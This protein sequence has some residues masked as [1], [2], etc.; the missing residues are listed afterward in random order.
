M[1]QKNAMIS[2]C[3][4]DALRRR[5]LL[6]QVRE[7]SAIEAVQT[8]TRQYMRAAPIIDFAIDHYLLLAFGVGALV[9]AGAALGALWGSRR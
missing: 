3:V 7:P 9:F 4:R 8:M 5:G 6:G 2:A 1:V